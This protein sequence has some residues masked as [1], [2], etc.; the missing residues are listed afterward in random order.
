MFGKKGILI[1]LS[2]AALTVAAAHLALPRQEVARQPSNPSDKQV[3]PGFSDE[4][5]R[6]SVDLINVFCSVWHKD[7]GAFITNLTRDDFAIY[8]DNKRQEIKNFA[9][10]TDLPLTI[11]L[12]IDTSQS[13]APKLKFEQ[14][15]A[16][17]FFHS[18]LRDRDRAALVEFD[19]GVTLVQDFTN[20]P[21]KMAKQIK[22]LRAAG[23]TALYDAI[24]L[25]CDEKLIREMGRKAM[26]I[27]SD[28]EDQSS[29]R[30]FEEA[31]EMA[32]KAEATIYSISVNRGGFF[33]VGDTKNGDRIMKEFS[34]QT[35]GRSFFPFKVE[36]LEEAFRHI[37]QELR[38][39]YSIGYLSSNPERNGAYRKVEI[40]IAEKGLRIS[41][42]RG[43]YA[44]SS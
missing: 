41:H 22:T 13:V 8:E 20:D 7:T 1:L 6:V 29:T 40:R 17:S 34:E 38:S 16:I 43:Y 5:Y 42:R 23:G 35:G 15:A 2:V 19:S 18:V 33:G 30:T 36:E 3:P 11:A 32:L 39:Q 21:N 9:R 10:E 12:L 14:E 26:V 27:L 44:P 28:G 4:T 25:T 24:Y 31:L 37:N